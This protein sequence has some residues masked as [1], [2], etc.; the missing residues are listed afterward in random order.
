MI[1]SRF[2]F[3]AFEVQESHILNCLSFCIADVYRACEREYSKK[4]IRQ[5]LD[6]STQLALL[7]I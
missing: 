5:V 7:N 2:S 4:D 1:N 3:P 6:L